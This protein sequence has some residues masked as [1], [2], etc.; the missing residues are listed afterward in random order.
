MLLEEGILTRDADPDHSQRSILSL[1]K[2][3]S[4]SCRC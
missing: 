1:Q 4:I 3:V 2:K